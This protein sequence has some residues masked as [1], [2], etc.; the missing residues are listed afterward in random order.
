MRDDTIGDD[1]SGEVVIDESAVDGPFSK[2]LYFEVLGDIGEDGV[3]PGG[4][5]LSGDGGLMDARFVH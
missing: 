3:D 1:G 5:G 4:N 2:I